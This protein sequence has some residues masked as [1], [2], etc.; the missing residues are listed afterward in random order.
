MSPLDTDVCWISSA[1]LGLI[2]LFQ[3]QKWPFRH[4]AAPEQARRRLRAPSQRNGLKQLNVFIR[5]AESGSNPRVETE[6]SFGFAPPKHRLSP[7]IS[8]VM[9]ALLIQRGAWGARAQMVH[10][11]TEFSRAS[12]ENLLVLRAQ[13]CT[14]GQ[15][16]KLGLKLRT[17][18]MLL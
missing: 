14:W 18:A 11:L 1:T 13:R 4:S 16:R 5:W 17:W 2:A 8:L 7:P 3:Q 12:G 10:R 6:R 9:S 15:N